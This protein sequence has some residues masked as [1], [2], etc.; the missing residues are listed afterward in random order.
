MTVD[1][2]GCEPILGWERA[3]RLVVYLFW[4]RLRF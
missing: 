2:V 4:W 3:P 1:F